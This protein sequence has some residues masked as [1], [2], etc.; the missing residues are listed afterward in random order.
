MAVAQH[1]DIALLLAAYALDA[2]PEE[3]D[4]LVTDHVQAC[5]LC[6]RQV[7]EFGAVAVVLPLALQPE[8]APA[9]L[10]RRILTAVDQPKSQAARPMRP[11][12]RLRFVRQ[13]SGGWLA[14]AALFLACLGVGGWGIGE[15]RQLHAM[16]AVA[17]TASGSGTDASGGVF[18]RAAQPPTVYV[19]NLPP[20]L[21][22]QVYEAW[23]VRRGVPTDAGIFVTSAAGVGGVALTD[24]PAAGDLVVIT[25]E[26]APGGATPRG[27]VVLQGRLEK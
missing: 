5:A 8:E 23:V 13:L 17:L 24:L 6:R 16:P 2:L 1:D 11:A 10:R 9:E 14:A 4:R 18:L 15:Y 27:S 3:D 12:R 20:P 22:E 7:G 19:R 25:R 21:P 26:P